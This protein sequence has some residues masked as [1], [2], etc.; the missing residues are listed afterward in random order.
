[1]TAEQN[2]CGHQKGREMAGAAIA[3]RVVL[4]QSL[5]ERIWVSPESSVILDFLRLG[6]GRVFRGLH[7]GT[8]L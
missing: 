5:R 4:W 1:M 8:Q 2:E 3:N 7:R 6:S